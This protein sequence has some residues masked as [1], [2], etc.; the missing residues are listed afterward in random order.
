MPTSPT[1]TEVPTP[2]L[3]ASG[4]KLVLSLPSTSGISD[5]SLD[6]DELNAGSPGSCQ[7]EPSAEMQGLRLI[8]CQS[9]L[10]S[11]KSLALC[12]DCQFPLEVREDLGFR[13]GLV[14][15]MFFFCTRCN[16][17]ILHLL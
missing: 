14:T 17:K 1:S 3:T 5:V 13:K 16:S 10:A 6:C 7:N 2:L 9:L 8:D 11:L 15:K 4:K 12:A